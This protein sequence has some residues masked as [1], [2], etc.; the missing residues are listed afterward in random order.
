M[1]F[2][3]LRKQNINWKRDICPPVVRQSK[4][5]SC[6]SALSECRQLQRRCRSKTFSSDLGGACPLRWS[7][8]WW[9]VLKFGFKILLKSKNNI[10]HFSIMAACF[11]IQIQNIP[12]SFKLFVRKSVILIAISPKQFWKKVYLKKYLRSDLE[13][14]KADSTFEGFLQTSF[15]SFERSEPRGCRSW[16]TH[17]R[18]DPIT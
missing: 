13:D 17:A 1:L 15:V 12:L 6:S 11:R 10:R 16:W 4:A 3:T 9:S 8:G 5:R 7:R 18:G 14:A 2:G